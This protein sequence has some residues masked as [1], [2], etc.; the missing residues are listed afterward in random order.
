MP[1]TDYTRC[2]TYGHAWFEAD[3]DWADDRG[4]PLTLRC[5]RCA[6]ERRDVFSKTTG[7][8]IGRRYVYP[9]GYHYS[10]G[11]R[12]SRD[13]FRLALITL[14]LREAGRRPRRLKRVS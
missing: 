3:S 11:S 1:S 13:D 8:L 4:H 10:A 7:E 2:G 12:P 9:D 5:E 14:R 6:T